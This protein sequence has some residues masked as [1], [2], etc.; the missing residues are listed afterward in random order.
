MK[1]QCI[2]ILTNFIKTVETSPQQ[3]S[4]EWYDI[5][6]TT[7]GGSEVAT[8][9]GLNPYDNVRKLIGNKLGISAFTGNTATRWGNLF[10]HVTKKWCED[11]FTL[12]DGIHEIGSV[13]GIIKNQRYSPDGLCIMKLLDNEDNPNWYIIL[14]EFKA[15]LSSLPNGIIPKHYRPQ[16]QTGLMSMPFCDYSVFINNCYRKCSLD[17][18]NYNGRYD[19][20]FHAG[21]YKKRKYGL[22]QEIPYACGIICFYQSIEEYDKLYKFYGADD[23]DDDYDKCDINTFINDNNGKDNSNNNDNTDMPSNY[24]QN[25]DIELLGSLNTLHDFGKINEQLFK[26]ILELY[27]QKRVGVVYYPI[28][29]NYKHIS[30]IPFINLH[31]L[32]KPQKNTSLQKFATKCIDK[33]VNLCKTNGK[34]SVGFL[35]WKLMRSN[36]IL[37]EPDKKWEETVK[38]PILNTIELMEKIM[39]APEPNIAYF[40]HF[41]SDDDKEAFVDEND[42]IASFFITKNTD[43]ISI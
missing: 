16:I 4:K 37:E 22:E 20:K 33:F 26:R 32:E 24:F 35:P 7:I 3:R 34:V 17:D 11:V 8:I 30:T 42:D 9:L 1:N 40:E 27:D 12:A 14:L 29:S 39:N 31:K 28:C 43:D 13:N 6:R 21:D 18:F 5:R 25:S 36:I 15:P 19:K 23:D 2:E 41:A 38:Q 10:E